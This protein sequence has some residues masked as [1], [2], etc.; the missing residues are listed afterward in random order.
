MKWILAAA[1]I[2]F[3]IGVAKAQFTIET[4]R[5]E[6]SYHGDRDRDR[7]YYGER[8]G[9][10]YRERGPYPERPRYYPPRRHCYFTGGVRICP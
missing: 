1:L 5:Y 10:Y 9:D 7:G 6:R 2:L 3:T 4:P 8:H